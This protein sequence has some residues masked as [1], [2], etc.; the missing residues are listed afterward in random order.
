M[1]RCFSTLDAAIDHCPILSA[2]QPD[3]T[4]GL[5][6][7]LDDLPHSEEAYRFA[8]ADHGDVPFSIIL[9]HTGQGNGPALHRHPYPEVWLVEEGEATFQV[10][11][12]QLVVPAGRVVIG[13]PNV[14]HAFTNTGPGQLRLVS[15]HGSA[16]FIT[17]HLGSHEASERRL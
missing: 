3:E 11:E 7:A 8:G 2:M 4:L 6:L 12:H 13:P 14:P 5:V 15:V 17:E 1:T 16:R 9:V 10:G